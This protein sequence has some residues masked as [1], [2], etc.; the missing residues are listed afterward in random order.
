MDTPDNGIFLVGGAMCPNRHG[1][2]GLGRLRR[3]VL[4]AVQFFPNQVNFRSCALRRL[5]WTS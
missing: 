5:A 1:E 3:N 4:V 2:V